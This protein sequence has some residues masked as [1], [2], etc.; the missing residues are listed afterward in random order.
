MIFLQEQKT[1]LVYSDIYNLYEQKQKLEAERDL[2]KEIIT[3]LSE[4]SVPAKRDNGLI[5]YGK[6]VIP[7]C[8]LITLLVLIIIANQRKLEEVYKNIRNKKRELLAPF[9][10]FN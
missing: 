7:I 4:F 2:Y 5:Y 8:F 9:F 1:Q 10:Y 3:V 6:Y